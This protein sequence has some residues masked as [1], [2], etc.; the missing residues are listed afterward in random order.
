MGDLDFGIQAEMMDR[1]VSAIRSA[2]QQDVLRLPRH[3]P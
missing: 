2:C 1:V 3:G